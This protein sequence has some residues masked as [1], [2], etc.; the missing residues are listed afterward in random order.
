M[1]ALDS[2]FGRG[3]PENDEII[4]RG[5][6]EAQRGVENMNRLDDGTTRVTTG[7]NPS[8]Q[9]PTYHNTAPSGA[10][11]RLVTEPAGTRVS[12]LINLGVGLRR[13]HSRMKVVKVFTIT[14]KTLFQGSQAKR[15][16]S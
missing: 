9:N 12:S 5:R 15:G 3:H 7:Q 16:A 4:N 2:V 14:E 8:T 6:E 10:A 1:N 13:F 11:T